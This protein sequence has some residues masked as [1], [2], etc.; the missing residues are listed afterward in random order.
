MLR[1]RILS[2][3]FD[4]EEPVELPLDIAAVPADAVVVFDSWFTVIVHT[5]AHVASWVKQV[6]IPPPHPPSRFLRLLRGWL[7]CPCMRRGTHAAVMSLEHLCVLLV[8][9][10]AVDLMAV[11][12]SPGAD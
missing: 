8:R 9:G 3:G 11:L 4:A 7:P 5:G 2:F 1:P 10:T 12:V 6:R